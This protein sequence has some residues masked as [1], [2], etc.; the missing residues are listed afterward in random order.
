MR[1]LLV[2]PIPPNERFG[3]GPFFRI[4]SLGLEY[5]GAALESHGHQV[6]LVDLRFRD[7]R[8]AMKAYRPRMVGVACPHTLDTNEALAVARLAKACDPQV[9][10]IVGGHAAAVYSVPF[11]GDG[12]DAVCC[13][14]GEAVV[15]ELADAIEQGRHLTEVPGLWVRGPGGFVRTPASPERVELDRVPLP[16]RHLMR[17]FQRHY[18]CVNKQPVWLV[19][20]ARGCPYRC[21]FCTIWRHVDRSY[22]CRGI[23][24]V[25]EDMA[26]TGANV[27]VADDLFFHPPRR[28]LDLARALRE[29]GILKS[30]MLVQTRTDLVARNPQVLEAWRPVSQDFDIFFG[31]E[32]PSEAELAN[33][34]KDS[35]I[36]AIREAVAVCRRFDVGITGNFI[37]DPDWG[38]E[39]F[40]RLWQFK[41]QLGLGRAGYTI[42][43]PLPGTPLFDTYRTRIL[44]A[45]WSKWDMHHILWEPRLGR[46][47]FFELFAES[48][49]RTVLNTG[50]KHKPWYEWIAEIRLRQLPQLA[51]VLLSTQRLMDP[52]AYLRD[53]FDLAAIRNTL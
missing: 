16:A 11:L 42:L 19:E 26:R 30:W 24:W 47:R 21:S 2:R 34:T 45:D 43:T 6:T 20:T 23:D 27:F 13:E 8:R 15:P 35:D 4:E 40:E 29:R 18:L 14:D 5:I 49:R 1:I 33:Y 10:T 46:K 9:F 39:D 25:C 7:L 51:K 12:V 3:L 44:E 22:R 41:E 36:D 28:S 17:P 37:I 38:Q 53:A 50:G 32:A 48:W 31:F 52:G